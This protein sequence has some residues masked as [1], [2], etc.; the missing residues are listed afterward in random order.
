MTNKSSRPSTRTSAASSEQ[1]PFSRR[2]LKLEH[3]ANVGPL[4]HVACWAGL[5]SF[6]L[7]VPAA[8]NWYLAVPLIVTLT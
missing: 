8:A 2:V 6:G 4:I 5:L 7:L 1:A 3:P